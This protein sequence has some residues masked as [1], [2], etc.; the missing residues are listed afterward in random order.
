MK[1]LVLNVAFLL[2]YSVSDAQ[3]TTD[4][5][6]VQAVI[7]KM[8]DAWN[9]HDYSYSGK[10]DFYAADA[11]LVNPVGM[12]WKN[13]AEIIKA[14]QVL[15][16]MMFKYSSAKSEL[17]DLRFLAPTVAVA[18][19]KVQYRF[20]QDHNAPDGKPVSRGDIEYV[21]LT[22]VFIK[23]NDEWKITSQQVTS[24]NPASLAQDPIKRQANR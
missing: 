14:H 16:E 4:K 7:Q 18:T 22:L 8:D 9:A 20:L 2:V 12:Y 21:M 15:G 10:Y 6:A 17:V 13:R 11:R 19:V 3:L 5:K 24:L 23:A 1:A